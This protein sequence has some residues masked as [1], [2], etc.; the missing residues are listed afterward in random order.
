[1]KIPIDSKLAFETGIHIGDGC[2]VESGRAFR[3]VFSGNSI[4]DRHFMLEVVKP[5]LQ[6]VFHKTAV[7]EERTKEKT[8]FKQHR[9][10]YLY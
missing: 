9:N 8:L 3:I 1:M 7:V 4:N 2:L 6:D 5:L 10:N